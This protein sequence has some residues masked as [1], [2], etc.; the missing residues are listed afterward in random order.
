MEKRGIPTVMVATCEFGQDF[1]E[2]EDGLAEVIA[3]IE[4]AD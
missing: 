2:L 3:E 4:G 1:R